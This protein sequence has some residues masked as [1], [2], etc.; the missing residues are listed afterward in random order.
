M[1]HNKKIN[2]KLTIGFRL[3]NGDFFG[4]HD[5][6]RLFTEIEKNTSDFSSN[7]GKLRRALLLRKGSQD[8]QNVKK[9]CELFSRTAGMDTLFKKTFPQAKH[10]YSVVSQ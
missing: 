2:A 4:Y 9:C 7:F 3:A 8:R 1:F 10:K 6:D 5:F